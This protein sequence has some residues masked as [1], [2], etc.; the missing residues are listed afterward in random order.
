[1]KSLLLSLFILG[2]TNLTFAGE[3]WKCIG[4]TNQDNF[5]LTASNGIGS[6]GVPFFSE[7][8]ELKLDNN[9]HLVGEIVGHDMVNV[10]VQLNRLSNT[11]GTAVGYADFFIDCLG[12]SSE[13][14]NLTCEITQN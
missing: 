13:N 1:M 9:Q 5:L 6:I 7:P 12:E 8:V 14:I 10:D 3:I 11:L 4:N 2:A